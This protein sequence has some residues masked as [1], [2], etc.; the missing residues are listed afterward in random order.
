M[1]GLQNEE[2]I[3]SMIDVANCIQG[4]IPEGK[5]GGEVIAAMT[6]LIAVNVRDHVPVEHQE[7]VLAEMTEMIDGILAGR[8]DARFERPN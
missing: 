8:I 7:N 6:M 2:D 1:F 4:A 3:K 5:N